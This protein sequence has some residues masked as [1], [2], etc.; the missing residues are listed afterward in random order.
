MCLGWWGW[1][2]GVVGGVGVV[3]SVRPGSLLRC[4]VHGSSAS[5]TGSTC[6]EERRL[7]TKAWEFPLSL[8]GGLLV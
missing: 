7:E 1:G 4:L 2:G 6:R 3:S 5:A 8:T